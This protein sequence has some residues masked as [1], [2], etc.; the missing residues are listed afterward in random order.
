M[1]G[2]VRSFS[3]LLLLILLLWGIAP[4]EAQLAL[5]IGTVQGTGDSSPFEGQLVTVQGVVTGRYRSQNSEGRIFHTLFVQA[6]DG[7][8]DGDPATADAIPVYVGD[9]DL[10]V[11]VGDE[12]RVSGWVQ[13]YYGL[14]ELSS[15]ARRIALIR[16]EQPLPTPIPWPGPADPEAME[17]YEAM[18]IS[19]GPARVAG[20][21]HAGCGFALLPAEHP[22]PHSHRHDAEVYD[23]QLLSVQF[24]DELACAELP[25]L[26]VGDQLGALTG[27]LNYHFD[28]WRLLLTDVG[29][30]MVTESALEA[31]SPQPPLAP[32]A[33]RLVSLNL[34]NYFDDL[35]D[36]DHE[37]EPIVPDEERRRRQEKIGAVIADLL[38]CPTLVAVQEVEKAALLQALAR[39]VAPAC[40]F[41]Y[42]VAHQE[43]VDARGI[44]VALLYDPSQIRLDGVQTRQACAEVSTEVVDETAGCGPAQWPLFSRPPL[45]VHMQAA[46]EPL[47]VI[48]VHLKSKRGGEVETEPIRLAQ[49]EALR[50]WRAGEIRPVILVGDVNDYRDAAPLTSLTAGDLHNVLSDLPPEQQYSF[51]FD[52]YAQLLDAILV[53]PEL[54][55]MVTY[56]T[57]QHSN[58][59]YPA[60]WEQDTGAAHRYFAISDHDI[61]LMEWRWS[62]AE[63]TAVTVAAAAPASVVAGPTASLPAR[64]PTPAPSALVSPTAPP[65]TGIPVVVTPA[66]EEAV[67][68]AGSATGYWLA[69]LLGGSLLLGLAVR[70]WL[71][72]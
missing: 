24:A 53:S 21:T 54:R 56:V 57:I 70:K 2:K 28:Q 11:Q 36:T 48:V 58:A 52:G 16:R 39:A 45:F 41:T 14:T 67:P 19:Y 43:S 59:D 22:D 18:L 27:P 55:E 29:Q 32:G 13:E 25:D 37:A 61:P 49:A 20:P 63:A 68:P 72:S 23:G 64:Q 3:F 62:A 8:G 44:D 31:P 40:G 34:H 65:A 9:N 66:R 1:Q 51:I 46:G 7:L 71:I 10:A 6:P 50:Q 60:R 38:R 69:A 5:P 26:K 12:I 30:L 42:G 15:N 47:L 33:I 17:P 4:V 35:R